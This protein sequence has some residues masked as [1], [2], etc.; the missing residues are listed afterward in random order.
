MNRRAAA[1]ARGVSATRGGFDADQV[2][3]IES[4]GLDWLA[5]LVELA[6]LDDVAHAA[7]VPFGHTDHHAY[8][9]SDRVLHRLVH[10][11]FSHHGLSGMLGRAHF[12]ANTA[13]M[14]IVWR[15]RSGL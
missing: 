6:G 7:I 13:R 3:L 4:L 2:L 1:R 14:A 11:K 15:K 8:K 12:S 9:S 5:I 10:G